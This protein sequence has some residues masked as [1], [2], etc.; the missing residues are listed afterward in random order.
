MVNA[1]ESTYESGIILYIWAPIL[2][3]ILTLLL[4]DK[5]GVVW[6]Y[7]DRSW[8]VQ[9]YIIYVPFPNPIYFI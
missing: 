8:N 9:F 4:G 1:T 6:G 7:C 3:Y 2:L 5:Q